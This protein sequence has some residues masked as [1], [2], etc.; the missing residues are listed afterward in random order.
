M[1]DAVKPEVSRLLPRWPTYR[2]WIRGEQQLHQLVASVSPG[3]LLPGQAS[4]HHLA[5]H[6]VHSC[7]VCAPQPQ[8]TRALI[9]CHRHRRKRAHIRRERKKT[10]KKNPFLLRKNPI[11]PAPLYFPGDAQGSHCRMRLFCSQKLTK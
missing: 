10:N 5:S 4:L 3:K 9:F 6:K 11:V 8:A 7:P 1:F 2:A